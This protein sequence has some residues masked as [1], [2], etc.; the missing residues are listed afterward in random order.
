MRSTEVP[1]T[2]VHEDGTTALSAVRIVH[3]S[4]VTVPITAEVPCG[5]KCP[6]RYG[7]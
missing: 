2:T 4:D 5:L 3:P 6:C 7:S 1:A